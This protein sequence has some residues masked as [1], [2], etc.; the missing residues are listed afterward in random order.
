MQ[1]LY[2][3]LL[4]VLFQ[5]FIII[6]D[7]NILTFESLSNHFIIINLIG[8]WYLLSVMVYIGADGNVS[9]NRPKLG[10]FRELLS[11]IFGFFALLIGSITGN[12]N[13]IRVS[14]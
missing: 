10:F 14:R 1:S 12:P 11:S 5:S 13:T 3:I 8:T 4:V 2:F 9:N 6:N 7:N